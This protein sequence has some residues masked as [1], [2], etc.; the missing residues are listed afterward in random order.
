MIVAGRCVFCGKF[1]GFVGICGDFSGILV[2][3]AYF[4][5]FWWYFVGFLRCFRE[6]AG[7]WGWY[8]IVF[9][10]FCVMVVLQ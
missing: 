1:A 6:F 10:L 8:N 9:L 3:L 5:T 2:F 4:V 7:I